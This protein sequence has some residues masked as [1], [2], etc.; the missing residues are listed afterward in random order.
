MKPVNCLIVDDEPIAREIMASHLEKVPNWE[1]KNTCINAE[2]AYEALLTEDI[3][4]VFLDIEM[5]IIS[6]IEFLQSLKNPPLVIFTTAYSE[7]ALRGYDLNVVDYLL[8][9]ITFHR[10]FQA[11]EKANL[12]L[13]ATA[14]HPRD[15]ATLSYIF[16][17]DAGKLKKINFGDI[18]Y[19]KAEQEY[20]SIVMANSKVLASKHLKLLIDVLPKQLFTRIHRSYIVSHHKIV[21]ISGNK[22]QM[23]DSTELPIGSTYREKLIDRLN[24]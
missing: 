18:V 8:K 7:Y 13:E 12:M 14:K 23:E 4:V 21:A 2:E 22:V 10:F 20:S 5:P 6:G 24:I 15:D 17:K 16:L 9:P 11:I 1:V 3:D 19:I